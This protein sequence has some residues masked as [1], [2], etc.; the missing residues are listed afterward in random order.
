MTVLNSFLRRTLAVDAVTCV[1]A[2]ALMT[3]AAAPLA[4][5]TGLPQL[6]LV[7]AGIALFPVAAVMAWL[8]R[9]RSAPAAL[10]WLVILGNAGW[11]AG[12]VAVLVLTAPTAFGTAFVAAQA[13]AVAV[14]TGL[15]YRGAMTG[16][17][18]SAAKAA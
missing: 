14:L 4:P 3:F 6:L 2:G 13:L 12:S 10:V 16:G 5:F 11:V 9:R 15:E 17:S 8:S 7:G 18:V 1:G